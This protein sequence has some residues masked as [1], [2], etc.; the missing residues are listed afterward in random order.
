MSITTHTKQVSQIASW[1]PDVKSC[2][3]DLLH[4]ICMV[5][6]RGY[7]T[8]WLCSPVQTLILAACLLARFRKM[9]IFSFY[10]PQ[11]DPIVPC[12]GSKCVSFSIHL[13][14]TDASAFLNHETCLPRFKVTY[15]YRCILPSWHV[16]AETWKLTWTGVNTDPRSKSIKP[17]RNDL[18]G[19]VFK[20]SESLPTF[21]NRWNKYYCSCERE[22]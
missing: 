21:F 7:E 8:P 18:L 19:E 12:C 22:V 6:V 9:L 5:V 11:F 3:N 14:Y 2:E 4:R 17:L 15:T 13:F 16:K 1:H 20:W 10:F